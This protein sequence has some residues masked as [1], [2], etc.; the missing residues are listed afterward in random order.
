MI[1]SL[2]RHRWLFLTLIEREIRNRYV[3]SMAGLFWAL[4][5]PLVLLGVY[6]TVFATIFRVQ[7]PGDRPFTSFVAVALWPWLAFQE[8]V[9]RGAQ[10]VRVHGSLVR[11][12][13]F[14]H[15]LLVFSAVAATFAVH[16][17]G[18]VLVLLALALFGGGLAW[19]GTPQVL[20]GL[21]FL[22]L[23]ALC[24]ALV[25]GAAE[26][27][28]P[29][30]DQFLGPAFMVLFYATPILYPLS[31]APDW[32]RG[33]LAWNPLLYLIEPIRG[34]LLSGAAAPTWEVWIVWLGAL[35]ALAGG[36]LLFRRL[37]P[38]FEDFL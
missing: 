4:V 24:G 3:G 19:T 16:L 1:P 7:L 25:L 38:H 18:Y 11:K 34:G 35:P 13:A 36:L 37:S 9:Q 31:I 32:L 33:I 27:F 22:F 10:A 17:A 12:V 6:A 5:H 28:V 8:S 29:D 26:V 23:L 2:W 20:A 14:P 30:L 21:L 15:E